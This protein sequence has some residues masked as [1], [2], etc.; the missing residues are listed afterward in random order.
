MVGRASWDALSSFEAFLEHSP[1]YHTRATHVRSASSSTAVV[2]RSSIPHRTHINRPNPDRPP[3]I[4]Q[5]SS[6]VNQE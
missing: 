4:D 1:S 2:S 6:Q 5:I 3:S